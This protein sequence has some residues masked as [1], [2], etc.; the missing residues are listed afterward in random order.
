MNRLFVILMILMASA[1]YAQE[2]DAVFSRCP[3]APDYPYYYPK[4]G[5]EGDFW[6]VKKYIYEGMAGQDFMALPH[7]TGLVSVHFW[8]NCR[9]QAG[10]FKTVCY[11]FDYKPVL[12]DE[13]IVRH[14]LALC[15]GLRG[16]I[17][18]RLEGDGQAVNS[19]KFFTFRIDHGQLVDILPQ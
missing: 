9:G 8:V 16:W 17:P 3:D 1:A 11:G 10:D 13:R 6:A 14:L 19:H 5:Y 15:R 2:T 7:N 18:A 12:V 4:L